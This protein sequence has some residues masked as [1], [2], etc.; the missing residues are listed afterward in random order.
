MRRSPLFAGVVYAAMLVLGGCTSDGPTGVVSDTS[1]APPPTASPTTTG[2]AGGS[3]TAATTTTTVA[4]EPR[5]EDWAF[6]DSELLVSVAATYCDLWP[7]VGSMA[8]EPIVLVDIPDDGWTVGRDLTDD[9]PA[10]AMTVVSAISEMGVVSVECSDEYL[11]NGDWIAVPVTMHAADGSVEDGLWSLQISPQGAVHWHFIFVSPIESEPAGS[12][13]QIEQA[14]GA[15]C[16]LF[17]GVGARDPEPVVAAMVTDPAIH[18]IINKRHYVGSDGV[19]EMVPQYLPEE[20][21]TCGRIIANGVWSANEWALDNDGLNIH[22]IGL[23]IQRH[24]GE[25]IDRQYVTLTQLTGAT[26]WGAYIW[27]ADAAGRQDI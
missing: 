20:R 5:D 10:G 17:E 6:A 8:A 11:V 4:V 9:L 22:L 24:D 1:S 3:T 21:I 27:G 25:L 12:D 18:N 2:S 14:A 19:A 16:E 15:F 13:A 26:P 23:T 7:D